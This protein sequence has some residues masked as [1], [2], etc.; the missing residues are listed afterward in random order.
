MNLVTEYL[1][2]SFE[3]K[4]KTINT[5]VIE[6]TKYFSK[7]IKALMETVNKESEEFELIEDYKKI[8]LSKVTK[9]IF[10][11]FSLE[12]NNATILKKLYTELE[13][14]INSEEIFNKKIEMES[15]AANI[16]DDL[17][18]M[19]RLSLKAG[20][21]NYQ[22][23]FK[24]LAIEFDY[25]K[26]SIIEKLIEYIKV[27]A[28]M[29]DIKLFII[30]NLDSFLTEEDLVELSKFLCYNEIKVLALQNKIT[31]QVKTCENLRILDQ[32]LCEI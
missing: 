20:D 7:F 13:N 30:I 12:A 23:F 14:D 2:N 17:I 16:V 32:D 27:T 22:Y 26:N 31:R 8:D 6:D 4:S 18:H 10:D 11:L 28:D 3:I 1:E 15:L 24:A 19:S 21:I 25:D 9:V 5:L 29:L